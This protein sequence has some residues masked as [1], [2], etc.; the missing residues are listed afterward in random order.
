MILLRC[1]RPQ[2]PSFVSSVL[3]RPPRCRPDP[4]VAPSERAGR[5]GLSGL[6]SFA[7]LSHRCRRSFGGSQVVRRGVSSGG[8][9]PGRCRALGSSTGA[10]KAMWAVGPNEK[11][12]GRGQRTSEEKVVRPDFTV[13]PS[14]AGESG[15]KKPHETHTAS[16]RPLRKKKGTTGLV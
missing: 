8:R 3:P 5:A 9:S 11:T 7:L 13:Q 1:P 16:V 4:R 10:A 15:A 6:G 12:G 2:L 14:Q